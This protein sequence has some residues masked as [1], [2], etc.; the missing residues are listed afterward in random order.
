MTY[1]DQQLQQL[2]DQCAR[3]KHLEAVVR[4]LRNQRFALAASVRELEG[5]MLEEQ[6]DLHS[7]VRRAASVSRVGSIMR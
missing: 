5:I 2:Q 1:Y 6:A 4:E 3:K 7:Q